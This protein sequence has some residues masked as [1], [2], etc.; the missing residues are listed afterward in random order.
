MLY[1][2]ALTRTLQ[3][4]I[5]PTKENSS[6]LKKKKQKTFIYLSFGFSG[7]AQPK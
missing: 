1:Q 3:D 2:P 5:H 6:F 4:F 7:L